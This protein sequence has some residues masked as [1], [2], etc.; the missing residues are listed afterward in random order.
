[1]GSVT[2]CLNDFSCIKIGLLAKIGAPVTASGVGTRRPQECFQ[3]HRYDG[4]WRFHLP[5]MFGYQPPPSTPFC[6]NSTSYLHKG[7]IVQGNWPKTGSDSSRHQPPHLGRSQT[8]NLSA[9]DN[10]IRPYPRESTGSRPL[11]PSQTRESQISS[12]VGDDQRI[13]GV[14][15]FCP[16]LSPS[17]EATP[18][19][20]PAFPTPAWRMGQF[21]PPTT[22]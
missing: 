20:T 4:G 1:M 12:W 9:P 13:P 14:V 22:K 5:T 21:R 8:A 6:P 16:F 11:S 19:P 10:H 7:L 3:G 2:V 17:P 15:C 18:A